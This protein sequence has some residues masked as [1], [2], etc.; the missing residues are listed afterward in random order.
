MT[1]T[2]YPR[3]Y[4][5]KWYIA[6]QSLVMVTAGIAWLALG[7][8]SPVSIVSWFLFYTLQ[9]GG[10][11]CDPEICATTKTEDRDGRKVKVKRPLIGFKWYESH[12]PPEGLE[13]QSGEV[14]YERAYL[15]I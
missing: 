10:F 15:R 11:V 3:P 5:T 4:F 8:D 12:E 14:R 1:Q 7:F 2:F 13:G 9:L 6:I